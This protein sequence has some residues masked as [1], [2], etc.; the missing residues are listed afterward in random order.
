MKFIDRYMNVEREKERE[1]DLIN[2][3]VLEDGAS[4]EDFHGAT[5]TTLCA[6][7]KLHLREVTFA[8][9]PLRTSQPF[10]PPSL[11]LSEEALP[12]VYCIIN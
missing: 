11:S 4:I 7:S 2:H 9:R 6:L 10:S 1:R 5:L 3:L 12:L 8:D